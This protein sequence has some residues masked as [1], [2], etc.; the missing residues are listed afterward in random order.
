MPMWPTQSN[1]MPMSALLPLLALLVSVGFGLLTW[2]MTRR[3]QALTVQGLALAAREDDLAELNALHSQRL[4]LAE[5]QNAACEERIAALRLEMGEQHQASNGTIIALATSCQAL[6]ARVRVYRDELQT[7]RDTNAA[8]TAQ[9][10]SYL[11]AGP[12]RQA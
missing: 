11:L 8:L 10:T 12:P 5:A 1:L 3:S 6:E 4:D 9:I 2:W 7:L